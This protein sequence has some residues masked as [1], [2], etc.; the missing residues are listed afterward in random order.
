MDDSFIESTREL[1]DDFD[2]F[3]EVAKLGRAPIR[4][5]SLIE[6]ARADLEAYLDEINAAALAVAWSGLG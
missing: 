5:L 2:R 4:A 3:I 1:C 6:R